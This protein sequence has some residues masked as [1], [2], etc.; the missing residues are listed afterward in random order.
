MCSP[1]FQSFLQHIKNKLDPMAKT[2]PADLESAPDDSKTACVLPPKEL[3]SIPT[4][5]NSD[6]VI[7]LHGKFASH[8]HCAIFGLADRLGIRYENYSQHIAEC[9]HLITTD[10]EVQGRTLPF[11]IR[12]AALKSCK[13][14]SLDWL[15]DSLKQ[16]KPLPVSGYELKSGLL[17][18]I[19]K[20]GLESVKRIW[21][22]EFGTGDSSVK[23]PKSKAVV[24][25][26][27]AD[28]VDEEFPGPEKGQHTLND[29]GLIDELTR[30]SKTGLLVWKDADIVY[31]ATMFKLARNK[32][33]SN[34][35][36][37]LCSVD[38]RRQQLLWDP[39]RGEY[40][41]WSYEEVDGV[42]SEANRAGLGDLERAKAAFEKLFKDSTGN[43]WSDR[44]KKSKSSKYI[45][46]E[47]H[48]KDEETNLT[49]VNPEKAPCNLNGRNEVIDLIYPLT[50]SRE[51]LVRNMVPPRG[52]KQPELPLNK[53]QM[54]ICLAILKQ[55]LAHSDITEKKATKGDTVT[56]LIQC[57][58]S[59]VNSPQ[60]STS[61]GL[62][63]I[64]NEYEHQ[65]YHRI[66][67][68]AHQQDLR[69][70]GWSQSYL[71]QHIHR[72]LGLL[73][74]S[75]TEYKLLRNYFEFSATKSCYHGP[76]YYQPVNLV[77]IFRIERLG[78]AERYCKWVQKEK[79]PR[80]LWHGSHI[81]NFQGILKQGL[82]GGLRESGIFASELAGVS[83]AYCR[84][85][86][87]FGLM[88]LCE[89]DIQRFPSTKAQYRDAGCIHPDL[90]G[91]E[92]LDIAIGDDYATKGWNIPL[93]HRMSKPDQIRMRYLFQFKWGS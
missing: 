89:V 19:K 9:T 77:N 51:A 29:I 26:F 3:R 10:L 86:Q 48:F 64:K 24:D 91:V 32:S 83:V 68:L 44:H 56:A 52:A 22:D 27:L 43:S 13:I 81:N 17:D 55:L 69:Y 82:R 15:L 73:D 92:M 80:L 76:N 30:I 6:H 11:K 45:F 37:G 36:V 42:I 53:H 31:D 70:P 50:G 58:Q 67:S 4:L 75:T 41:T 1:S 28:L 5:K 49:T 90:E 2:E 40:Y 12:I 57:Y 61:V 7:A 16:E 20:R 18:D 65:S 66:I 23:A 54:R 8:T 72:A 74:S 60:L 34:T 62:D 71:A 85:T 21:E 38:L 35:A 93:E 25:S 59:L 88:L 14:I 78:E 87:G 63:W 46:V 47:C 84:C 33:S 39:H 79:R